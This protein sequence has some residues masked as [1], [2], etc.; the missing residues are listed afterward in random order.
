MENQEV[1]FGCIKFEIP[2]R[3]QVVMSSLQLGFLQF[4]SSEGKSGLEV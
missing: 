3:H 4:C 2:I 1:Y